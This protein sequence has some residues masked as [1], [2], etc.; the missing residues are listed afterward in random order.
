MLTHLLP[1]SNGR[2]YYRTAHTLSYTNFVGYS[3]NLLDLNTS[4]GAILQK[5]AWLLKLL[6]D[7]SG[8]ASQDDCQGFQSSPTRETR[9]CF[10]NAEHHILSMAMLNRLSVVYGLDIEAS[11][12]VNG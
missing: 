4:P 12:I 11:W 6:P 9:N 2:Q 1:R 5:Y 8:G 3:A 7:A 10:L